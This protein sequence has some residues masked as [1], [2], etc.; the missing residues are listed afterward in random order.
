MLSFIA[1]IFYI[2][3]YLPGLKAFIREKLIR[4]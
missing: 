1:P 4:V 2:L 3:G